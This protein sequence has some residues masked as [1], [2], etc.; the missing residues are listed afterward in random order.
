[1]SLPCIAKQK[2][3]D[4]WYSVQYCLPTHHTLNINV[5]NA[6]GSVTF[7]VM[8]TTCTNRV[9]SISR[10]QLACDS[11]CRVWLKGIKVLK[12]TTDSWKTD[13]MI[14]LE[15]SKQKTSCG[16]WSNFFH[17]SSSICV[18]RDGIMGPIYFSSSCSMCLR[19]AEERNVQEDNWGRLWKQN[20]VHEGWWLSVSSGA[21]QW[22]LCVYIS[23]CDGESCLMWQQILLRVWLRKPIPLPMSGSG[24]VPD[25]ASPAACQHSKNMK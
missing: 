7:C 25:P 18:Q 10:S 3:A 20:I 11:W 24:I 17:I 4:L 22:W 5:L 2:Q 16:N 13:L 6:K 9:P 19:A 1:M 14:W 21:W 15:Y 8:V 12:D 23:Q